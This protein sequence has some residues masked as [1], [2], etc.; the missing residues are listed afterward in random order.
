M[1][2]NFTR[3]KYDAAELE[4]Y[5]T[6]VKDGNNYIMNPTSVENANL[7]YAPAG[8]R[9]AVS[10][11]ARPLNAEGFLNFETKT[12]IENKLQNRH[13][14]LNSL[15]RTNK[16][17][18]AVATT[19]PKTCDNKKEHLTNEDTRF[20]HPIINYRGMYT[21]THK[22]TPYLHM[23]PQKVV[24]ENDDHMDP[25]RNGISTRY[26]SKTEFYDSVNTKPNTEKAKENLNFAEIH[27]GLLPVNTDTITPAYN[28]SNE[29]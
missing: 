8:A 9:N 13:L 24:G 4:M 11:V 2:N 28:T 5:N 1:A 22:F 15:E 23:N 12:D 29:I 18:A 6:S 7:C 10:Q 20:T 27:R 25:T 17:Y 26:D 14:P 21:A 19:I 16:D 3:T